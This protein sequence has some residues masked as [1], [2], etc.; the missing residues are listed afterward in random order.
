[1]HTVEPLDIIV[2]SRVDDSDPIALELT[3]I[4]STLLIDSRC[5]FISARS[6]CS[7]DI[8]YKAFRTLSSHRVSN[9]TQS[10]LLFIFPW[11]WIS[12]EIQMNTIVFHFVS[13]LSH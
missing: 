13:R 5:R 7:V 2:V 12:V 3:R 4:E 10:A 1:M 9:V 6:R 8:P 11:A